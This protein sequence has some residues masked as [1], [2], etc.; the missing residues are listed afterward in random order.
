[1]KHFRISLASVVAAAVAALVAACG[2][3]G[4]DTGTSTQITSV[5]VF[6]DSLADSGTF[7]TK[8]TV[9]G[10][11]GKSYAIYPDH[12]AS[13]YGAPALC[14]YF[15]SNGSTFIQNPAAGCSNY[16]IGGGRINH[17][18]APTTP[19][20]ITTQLSLAAAAGSYKSTDMVVI[21]GG[22]ND[23]ADLVGA[24]LTAAGGDAS[25]LLAL[26]SSLLGASAATTLAQTNGAALLGGQYMAA[27][28]NTFYSSI[29]THVLDKG[30]QHVVV[31]NIPGITNTPRFQMVL[32]GIAV[33][34]GGGST[35]A[36]A[37]AQSETLFKSWIET[38]NTALAAKIGSDGRV[39]LV[40]VYAALN[41]EVANPK[42][43][44]LQNA[45]DAVCPVTGVGSDKLPTYDFPT[46]TDTAL[47]AITPPSGATGG[48]SWWKTYLFSDGFHPTPYGHQLTFQQI[49]LDLAKSGRL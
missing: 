45:K 46:C 15:L 25:S 12:I 18:T 19:L 16:A 22:G 39:V 38:F 21:D 5:K 2:G 37:R 26:G 49:A 43:Y 27:L 40:D 44:G 14:P 32:D 23:A 29:K 48:S 47:S 11:G 30:A 6:G 35:G 1:M 10:N 42:Q 8:F 24:Y 4:S 36:A 13:T 9:Q 31:L 17:T 7:G 34:Y 28:A 41:R 3:G 20:S 33:S